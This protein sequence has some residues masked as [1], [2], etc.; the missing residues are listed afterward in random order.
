VGTMQISAGTASIVKCSAQFMRCS[1][2]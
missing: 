2:P 1:L